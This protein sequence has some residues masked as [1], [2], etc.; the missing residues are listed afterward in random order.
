M[1]LSARGAGLKVTFR[2]KRTLE[3][4]MRLSV[5][6]VALALAAATPSFAGT[7]ITS[8]ISTPA[9][10]GRSVLYIETD[11]VRS[12]S[13]RATWI[14]RADQNTAYLLYPTAKKFTRLTAQ[15]MQQIVAAREKM[16]HSI[17]PA[18][19]AQLA[20]N[21]KW[22]P[23]AQRAA[24]QSLYAGQAPKFEFRDVGTKSQVGKWTCERVDELVDGQPLAGLCV[25]PVSDLGASAA[26]FSSLQRA[27]V[28]FSQA[29]PP[30][31]GGFPAHDP[32]AMKKVVGYAA[33]PVDVKVPAAK[34]ETTIETVETKPLT[35]DLFE[36]PPGYQEGA[37]P[38][39]P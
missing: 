1:T 35:A 25:V 28:F 18:Q 26:D 8:A 3:Q 14:F 5:V 9:V 16:L 4:E 24:M 20:E 13:P 10:S 19:R 34:I 27:L 22:L 31:F 33:F 7:V 29:Y 17:S 15:K 23:A 12:E 11:R 32:Q 30:G 38:V 21:L 36:V 37:T 2:A 39:R 6:A